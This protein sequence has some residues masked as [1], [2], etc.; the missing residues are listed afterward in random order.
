MYKLMT[1]DELVEKVKAARRET[2]QLM[3]EMTDAVIKSGDGAKLIRLIVLADDVISARSSIVEMATIYVTEKMKATDCEMVDVNANGGPTYEGCGLI[4]RPEWFVDAA[5]ENEEA[6]MSWV[7]Y[8]LNEIK[9]E[10][11]MQAAELG[12]CA[13]RMGELNLI[14]EAYKEIM[15]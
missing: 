9:R 2:N 15:K 12:V 7:T 3:K 8:L 6:I 11:D 14:R 13:Y 1:R 4:K 5:R 10:P